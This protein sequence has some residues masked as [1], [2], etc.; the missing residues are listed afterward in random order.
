MHKEHPHIQVSLKDSRQGPP[1][2]G[3]PGQGLSPDGT[4]LG[5]LPDNPLKLG[6]L[7][8]AVDA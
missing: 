3:V 2:L 1:D 5:L 6:C 7:N 8:S 4:V